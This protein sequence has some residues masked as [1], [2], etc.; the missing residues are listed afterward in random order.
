MALAAAAR[1]PPEGLTA[2]ALATALR[3]L[4]AAPALRKA[5]LGV[6]VADLTVGTWLFEH[7]ADALRS[8]ASNNKLVTTAAA[9]VELGAAFEFSTTVSAVGELSGEGVLAGPLVVV[10]R[11]D[12][13]LSGRFHG[14]KPTAV[15]EQ[16][17]RAVAEAGVREV[18]GGIVVDDAY[19][20]RQ[21]VHPLWPEAQLGR[22]YCAPVGALSFND[23]CVRVL[24]KPGAK[25][26]A[27][28]LCAVVPATAYV[29]LKNACHTSPPR[30]GG[31]Q[32]LVHRRPGTNDVHISGSIRQDA[33]PF[34]TW[35]TVHDPG[36]F[37]ATVFGEVLAAQGVRVTGPVRRR[38]QDEALDPEARRELITTTSTLGQAAAVANRRSQNFY[39][40]QLLKTLGRERGGG[41]SWAAGAQVVARFLRRARVRG[42]FEYRDGSG[43]A[44][45]NRF[46]PRQLVTLLAWMN[47]RRCGSRY[48]RSLAEP[49]GDGTLAR[50]HRLA[51]LKGRLFAKTGHIAGVSALSGYLDT[52]GGRMVAFAI[53][54]NGYRTSLGQVKAVQDAMS[55]RIADYAPHGACAPPRHA[56]PPS[57]RHAAAQASTP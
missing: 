15:L 37:A 34:A 20:D 19:F 35:L 48:L 28:A 18:G 56:A 31:N 25:P 11:G 41:G 42:A 1:P 27:P 29:R 26:G 44:R 22:W 55:L 53:L 24:V 45:A 8:V 12:P 33:E 50:R 32:V 46:T 51:G 49:G 40:E 23:N 3:R 38:A 21:H 5:R 6:A 52:R 16:W 13:S 39:A 9:L 57:S 7:Q 17:A 14:G 54:V 43:L 47:T 4:A 30:R 36:L 10:G 2:D